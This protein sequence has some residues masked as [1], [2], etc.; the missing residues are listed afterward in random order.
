MLMW[1]PG[2]TVILEGDRINRDVP[3]GTYS[4]TTHGRWC[5]R[6]VLTGGWHVWEQLPVG[7]DLPKELKTL[8]LLQGITL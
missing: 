7:A 3:L 2:E 6:K 1:V 4:R 8:A 5:V